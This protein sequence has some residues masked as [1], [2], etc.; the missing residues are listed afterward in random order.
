M[1]D[2]AFLVAG[3]CARSGTTALGKALNAH[4]DILLGNER[5][6]GRF[7]SGK[8]TREHFE[9][10]R[11]LGGPR[12]LGESASEAYDRARIIGDKIPDIAR[13]YRYVFERF[14][15]V[16]IVYIVRN[17]ISVAESYEARKSDPSDHWMRNATNAIATWNRSVSQTLAQLRREKP[18]TVVSYEKLFTSVESLG[19]LFGALGLDIAEADQSALAG[20]V[21]EFN[22]TISTKARARDETLRRRIALEADTQSY[23]RIVRGHCILSREE[24]GKAAKPKKNR[25]AA[26]K[27]KPS[28]EPGGKAKGGKRQPVRRARQ[29]QA[30]PQRD[31]A[32]T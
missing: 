9:K 14:P 16:R 17:P 3:G 29:M 15:G 5:Y 13:T 24:F 27:A 30:P 26:A 12:G 4:P 22:T 23:R 7:K 18:V 11:F 2:K 31:L 20:L 25:A 6:L 19:T 28:A 32:T 1:K 8:V 21:E 10:E